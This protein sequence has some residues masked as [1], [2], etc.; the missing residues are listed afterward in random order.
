MRC[1]LPVP[2]EV[3]STFIC[4][5]VNCIEILDLKA[6]RVHSHLAIAET[7]VTSQN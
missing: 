6:V 2:E 1:L 5:D 7:K 4:S 3:L